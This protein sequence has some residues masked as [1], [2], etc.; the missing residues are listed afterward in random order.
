MCCTLG[1]AKLTKTVLYAAEA[2]V[3][4]KYVHVLGYQNQAENLTQGPNAM[5]LP[6]P[7]AE[8]MGSTNVVDTSKCQKILTNYA[9][10]VKPLTRGGDSLYA[11]K[12][13]MKSIQVFDTGNYT[14]VLADDAND[15]PSAL[16]QVPVSKRPRINDAVFNAY[17]KWYPNQPIALCCFEQ[18]AKTAPEPM[19]WYYVP[20]DPTR[21]FAPALDA[22]DGNPPDLNQKVKVDTAVIFGSA[23]DPISYQYA[24]GVLFQDKV[25]DNV[26]PFLASR[27]W[28]HHIDNRLEN[29]DFS[30][31]ISSLNN[32]ATK[33]SWERVQPPGASEVYVVE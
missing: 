26:R 2:K 3:N 9:S 21:L 5:I 17:S 10:A 6:F 25:P 8:S 22:H 27:V 16:N 1:L 12:G 28:G 13:A 31:L 7:A 33:P 29:G 24:S 18:G 20:K 23:C 11:S 19:L 15:I 14:V 32:G 30:L 4:G